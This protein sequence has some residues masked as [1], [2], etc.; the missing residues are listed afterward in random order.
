[1]RITAQKGFFGIDQRKNFQNNLSYAMDMRNFRITESGSV[2]KRQGITYMWG[3]I[4]EIDGLWSGN[5]GDEGALFIATEG[6]LYK[7][8]P[9]AIPTQPILLG[10]IGNGKCM[11]FEFS[12]CLYIKTDE[13]YSKYDGKTLSTVEGYIPTVAISC[14]PYGEGE[15]FDQINLLTPKRRQ[16]FSGNGSALLYIL[17]EQNIDEV[18]SI[19]VDGKAYGD[20][21]SVDNIKG[22]ISFKSAPAEGLNN[23]EII[24]SKA[25][26]AKDKKRILGCRK[27]MHFGGNSDG[28]IFLWG[29]DDYPNYRFH[30]EL[31]N[32]VPS[33][34]YFPINAFTII[35][36]SR[37]N[38]IVQQYDKQLIFTENQAYYSYCELKEDAL[39]NNYSSFP[40]FNL[41]NGKGCLFETNGCVIDNKPITLCLDGLNRW[42][43]TSVQ[44][45]KNAICFSQPICEYVKEIIGSK[46]SM[47]LFDFQA[48]RELYFICGDEAFIYNY[49]NGAWY[50]YDG[51][52]G[53]N[54][55][56][57][58]KTLYFSRGSVLFAF[59]NELEP[60][61]E[62][63][64]IWESP[65]I[66]AG[67][68]YGRC[69]VIRVDAD[70][71]IEGH[72]DIRFE[73]E[74]SGADHCI[75]REMTFTSYDDRY[76]RISFRPAL[77]RA[78]P[79]RIRFTDIGNG[80]CTLH[81]LI[82]K[83]RDKERSSRDGIL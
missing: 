34:E 30:S 23:I 24:Y 83:T 51:F 39:G 32:G 45:E 69:D 66:S 79:F 63:V 11:M 26:S 12:G 54:Y 4:E 55:T 80:K 70:I 17:A 5:I 52:S 18:I 46:E 73:L 43:S 29:N 13:I 65:Y 41:N 68:N 74:K 40:V 59:G 58:E 31:A 21:Y 6:Q 2:K 3:G 37:I 72:C 49:G 77:K 27:I 33:A 38:C 71:R 10:N 50:V 81:G 56:I 19:K 22:Q 1:M 28:R 15:I 35:G 53:E 48:N 78:M 47:H 16:L 20:Q 9:Y 8:D 67:H 44:N 25:H 57:Y 76:M 62:C 42:E 7:T 60:D 75:A 82:I 14:T 36:N 61:S 64:C